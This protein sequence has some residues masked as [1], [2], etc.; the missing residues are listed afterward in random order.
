[1]EIGVFAFYQQEKDRLQAVI[2]RGPTPEGSQRLH[3]SKLVKVTVVIEVIQ[4]RL[5]VY[6]PTIDNMF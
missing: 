3:A 4:L 5:R 6:V 1:M 2:R